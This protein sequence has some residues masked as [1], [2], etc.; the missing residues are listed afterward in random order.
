MGPRSLAIL[1]SPRARNLR[2]TRDVRN[3]SESVLRRLAN[4]RGALS[5]GE[6]MVSVSIHIALWPILNDSF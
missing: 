6:S 1:S 2:G 5:V 3:K 4:V